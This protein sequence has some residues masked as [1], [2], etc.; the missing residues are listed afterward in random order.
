MAEGL[1]APPV[2]TGVKPW[3]ASGKV[4]FSRGTVPTSFLHLVGAGAPSPAP[5]VS[6][7]RGLGCS[8][9]GCLFF[10]YP[11][12]L[13]LGSFLFPG[14]RPQASLALTEWG[15]GES[16]QRETT[17]LR[18]LEIKQGLEWRAEKRTSGLWPS[19]WGR[20]KEKSLEQLHEQYPR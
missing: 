16:G 4:A 2:S 6:A 17:A 12:H 5:L 15:S 20:V 3:S 8:S 9:L 18:S 14:K 13:V 10:C 7:P 11:A 19:A 1:L